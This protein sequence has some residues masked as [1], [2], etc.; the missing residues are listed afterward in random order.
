MS[1]YLLENL[2]HRLGRPRWFWPAVMAVIFGLWVLG[3]SISP[4]EFEL[5]G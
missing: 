4:A 2:Y 3:S 1:P 5:Q